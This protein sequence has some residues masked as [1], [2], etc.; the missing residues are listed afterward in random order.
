V[1]LLLNHLNAITEPDSLASIKKIL[2]NL[3]AVSGDARNFFGGVGPDFKD[4]TGTARRAIARID[5]IA[6]DIHKIS[7]TINGSLSQNQLSRIITR[8]DSTVLSIKNVSETVNLMVKQSR[9]DFSVS[10]QNLREA[11]ENANQLIKELS[12]NPS[13]ILKGEQQKERER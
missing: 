11:L 12:E 8:V 9:E 7:G 1:E 6:G 3:V 2:D 10:M 5:S 4:I 13:L